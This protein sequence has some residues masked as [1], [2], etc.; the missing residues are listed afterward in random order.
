MIEDLSSNIIA[1]IQC[2]DSTLYG[3]LNAYSRVNDEVVIS[4]EVIHIC[5]PNPDCSWHIGTNMCDWVYEKELN[6]KMHMW[7]K[8]LLQ[9]ACWYD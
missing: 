6:S 7:E 4:N 2:D 1:L 3:R 9:F 8:G 5:G